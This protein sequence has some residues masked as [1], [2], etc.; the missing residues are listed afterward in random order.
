MNI[1]A[2]QYVREAAHSKYPAKNI[3]VYKLGYFI[4]GR[5]IA[6]NAA[7]TLTN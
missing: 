3:K 6:L 5:T 1:D 4:T 7:C 2:H